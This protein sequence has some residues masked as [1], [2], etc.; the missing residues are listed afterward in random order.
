MTRITKDRKIKIN[1][2]KQKIIII[3]EDTKIEER[4]RSD[5]TSECAK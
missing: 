3:N 4:E 1:N 5:I 2:K